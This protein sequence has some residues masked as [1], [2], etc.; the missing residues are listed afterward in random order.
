[1]GA[2]PFAPG[3]AH[4]TTADESETDVTADRHV[5]R[6]TSVDAYIGYRFKASAANS[7]YLDGLTLRVGARNLFNEAPPMAAASWTDSNADTSTYNELGRVMYVSAN[8]KF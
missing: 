4:D 3:A 5:E 6:Y 2:P 7:R 8:Y 1:M